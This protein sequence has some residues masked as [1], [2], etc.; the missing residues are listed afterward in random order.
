MR[1]RLL[2]FL[3]FF[4]LFTGGR[5]WPAAAFITLDLPVFLASVDTGAKLGNNLALGYVEFNFLLF[6]AGLELGHQW[7]KTRLDSRS[8]DYSYPFASV[9]GG[10]H[11]PWDNMDVYANGGVSGIIGE[12]FSRSGYEYD[13]NWA[14]FID[15][16][17]RLALCDDTLVLGLGLRHTRLKIAD[18]AG[19][20]HKSHENSIYF[21]IGYNFK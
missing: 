10:L 4:S 9:Y 1:K 18:R 16:G 11:L 7:G 14:W 12:R 3:L 19:E 8:L 2:V 20:R 17:Y 13:R 5:P 6:N 15:G 21:N